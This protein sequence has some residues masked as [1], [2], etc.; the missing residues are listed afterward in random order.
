MGLRTSQSLDAAIGRVASRQHGSVTHGQLRSLDLSDRMIAWR[1]T[2]GRL[3]PVHRGVYAVGRPP[4]TPLERAGAAVLACGPG[5][6]LSHLGA[7]ALW[8]FTSTWPAGFDVV[9]TTDRR[10][11]GIATHRY[12]GLTRRDL[13]IQLGIRATSPARTLLDCTPKLDAKQRTRTVND[14]LHSP[15][16]TQAQLADVRAR[17]RQHPGARLLDPYLDGTTLTRSPFEDDF[18][19]FCRHHGLPQPQ[20]NV[21]VAGHIVD[22]LFEPA[23]L[24]VELDGWEYHHDR[25]AFETDRARDGDTLRAGYRTRRVTWDRLHGQ[26]AAEADLLLGVLSGRRPA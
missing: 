6:A 18:L 21:P 8:G 26:P 10:P 25:G 22:A 24:I 11:A 1:V 23:R 4:T 17:F 16:L 5:A 2:Q 3:Y 13:R 19:A 12:A 15:F 14:A 20:L 7:L 9:V